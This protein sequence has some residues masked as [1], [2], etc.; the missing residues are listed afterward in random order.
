MIERKKTIAVNV[1]GVLIG[2]GNPIIIQSMTNTN[3]SDVDKIF[4]QIKE[5][6]DAGSEIVRITV[7]DEK[8]AQAVP[9]IVK[10]LREA[11]YSVPI[12]GDFHYNGHL[13]L[14]K[15][16]EC[17]EKLDKYRINPGNVGKG[18]SHD[19]NFKK[20]IELAIKYDKP[21]RIGVNGGSLDLELL[22]ELMSEN[23]LLKNPKTDKEIFYEAL[24][25]SAIDSA[26]LAEKYGLSRDKIILG[27]KVSDVQDFISVT[28]ELSLRCD[29][30]LHVG[31]TEAGMGDKGIVASSAALGVLLQKGIGD[32]IRVSITSLPG[33]SREK[34]VEIC[35]L[36]LQT[37]GFRKF[38]PM[39]TSCP[40]CGRTSND[41]FQRLAQEMNTFIDE[42]VIEWKTKKFKGFENIK[43]AV[44]GCIVNGPG[45]SKH[46][47]IGISFPGNNEKPSLP[48]YLDG[49]LKEVL[50]GSFE[51]V[52]K[53][54]QEIVEEYVESKYKN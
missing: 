29:Y 49:E 48:V 38:K 4:E 19:E 52:K 12:I 45:E 6:A 24:I 16:P 36:L 32:T 14:E 17:A 13:L 26:K 41:N 15:F 23:S 54:F 18:K 44:M 9:L 35:R 2:G 53:R 20:F 42:K 51:E 11:D 5:L 28:E 34:E 8:A 43:I 50:T 3:T 39:I 31:L 1:G 10:K 22:E 33:K 47:N 46:A 25:R 27:V 7:N 30:A 21:I 37:M 40:G